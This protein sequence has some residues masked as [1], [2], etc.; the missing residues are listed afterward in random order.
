VNKEEGFPAKCGQKAR[1]ARKKEE[2]MKRILTIL[3][4]ITASVVAIAASAAETTPQLYSKI[5]VEFVNP[6]TTGNGLET[7]YGELISLREIALKPAGNKI[8]IVLSR[9]QIELRN[10][11][12]Y[13]PE[14]IKF[15]LKAKSLELGNVPGIMRAPH[16]PD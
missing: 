14:E 11:D 12:I 2:D 5:P 15:V 9:A 1:P 10:G 8:G 6:S 3:A 13:Y 4:V 16:T 7:H